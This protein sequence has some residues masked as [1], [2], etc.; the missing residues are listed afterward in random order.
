MVKNEPRKHQTLLKS[1]IV[2]HQSI[3]HHANLRQIYN[4][5]LSQIKIICIC[6]QPFKRLSYKPIPHKFGIP[7]KF[8]CQQIK[9]LSKILPSI[10]RLAGN[11]CHMTVDLLVFIPN[12]KKR[13]LTNAFLQYSFNI[14]YIVNDFKNSCYVLGSIFE[15]SKWFCR[16]HF[17]NICRT[18]LTNIGTKAQKQSISHLQYKEWI[19]HL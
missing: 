6:H 7:H 4:S 13:F 12:F 19:V 17:W 8:R 18:E 11:V 10:S 2:T 5:L 3:F 16:R 15:Q 9:W 14:S 1:F